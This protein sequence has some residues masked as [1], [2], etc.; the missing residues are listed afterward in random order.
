MAL[1]DNALFLVHI[2]PL[3]LSHLDFLN[4]R[5][6][7]AVGDVMQRLRPYGSLLSYQL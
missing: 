7:L 4:F 5:K 3:T 6:F 1:E 2:A